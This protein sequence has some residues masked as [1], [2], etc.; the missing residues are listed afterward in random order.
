M[1]VGRGRKEQA[2]AALAPLDSLEGI[3]ELRA[4]QSAMVMEALGDR[5]E[6]ETF[7]GKLLDAKASPW[8]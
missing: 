2:I 5:Q 6:A 1:R 7:Y 8:R 4:L 3:A